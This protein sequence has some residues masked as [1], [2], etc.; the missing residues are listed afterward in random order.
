M[1]EKRSAVE[2]Y[3][4]AAEKDALNQQAKALG[5]SRGK[6]IRDRALGAPTS[7]S[8]AAK[9]PMSL[10]Q[11]QNGVRAALAASQGCAPRPIIEAIAAAVLCAAH[12]PETQISSAHA[13]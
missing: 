10:R 2:V 6:L 13:E 12:E 8:E 9:P 4:T 3:L 7:P 11:Y 5:L 1:N